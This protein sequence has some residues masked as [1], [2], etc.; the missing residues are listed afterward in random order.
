MLF[1]KEKYKNTKGA[2]GFCVTGFQYYDVE[3]G[4]LHKQVKEYC[5][6]LNENTLKDGK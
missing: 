5:K 2:L 3:T 4:K 1:F 6:N